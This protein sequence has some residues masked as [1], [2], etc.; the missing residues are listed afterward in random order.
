[1]LGQANGEASVTKNLKKLA[2]Y[3]IEPKVVSRIFEVIKQVSRDLRD[4]QLESH[5]QEGFFNIPVLRLLS[6]LATR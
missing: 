4:E 6:H 5:S 2:N 3:V 1:M